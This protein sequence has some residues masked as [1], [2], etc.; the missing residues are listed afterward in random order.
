MKT[1][2]QDIHPGGRVVVAL[3]ALVL[4]AAA[5]CVWIAPPQRSVFAPQ[6]PEVRV[7][8]ATA[9]SR[10]SADAC[11]GKVTADVGILTAALVALGLGFALVAVNGRRLLWLK[12]PGGLEASFAD[13]EK[14]AE[15]VLRGR[16]DGGEPARAA[17]AHLGAAAAPAP[18]PAPSGT[19]PV[20]APRG[21]VRVDGKDLSVFALEDV[22]VKVM[23]DLLKEVRDEDLPKLMDVEFAARESG[24]GNHPWFVKFRDRGTVFRVAYGGQGKPNATVT[25]V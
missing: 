21:V 22:P 13:V 1:L 17:E 15:S 9:T 3:L 18:A 19:E 23:R 16:L 7:T 25:L 6:C 12:V 5:G 14:K 11:V 10:L 4:F 2:A 20:A 8:D 24:Q